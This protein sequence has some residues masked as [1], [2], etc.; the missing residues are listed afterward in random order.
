MLVGLK[1]WTQKSLRV[2][3]LGIVGSPGW[4]WEE[5]AG[6]HACWG[7]SDLRKGSNISEHAVAM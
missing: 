1:G 2:A 6:T 5:K 7:E 4:G 3:L